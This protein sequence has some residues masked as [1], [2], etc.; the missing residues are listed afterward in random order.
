MSFRLS[1]V[2]TTPLEFPILSLDF[3]YLTSYLLI[4]HVAQGYKPLKE[5]RQNSLYLH[6]EKLE[7]F[8]CRK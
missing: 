8:C 6:Q 5:Q 2:I 4:D 3:N 7:K 1:K